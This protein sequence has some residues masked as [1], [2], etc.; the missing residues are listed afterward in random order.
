VLGHVLPYYESFIN[1]NPNMTDYV[2][3]KR[4]SIIFQK[5]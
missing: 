3:S 1:A 4:F 2:S 5:F